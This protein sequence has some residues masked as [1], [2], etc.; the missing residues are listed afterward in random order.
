MADKYIMAID[1]GTTGTRVILFNHSGRIHSMAYREIE[2]IF[3]NPGW[4]E[5]NPEEYWETTM[6]CAEE[7]LAEGGASIDEVAG[8]GI[9]NQRETT[10]LWDKKTGKPVYNA[11]VWQCRRTADMCDKLKEAGHEEKIQEKTGLLIDAYFSG[12]KIKWI[13][14]NVPEA[15]EKLEQGR[16]CMGTIDS[17][18]I[19]KLTGGRRHVTDYSNASRTMLLNVHDLDWDQELFDI[20][21]LPMEIMPE[22]APSSGVMAETDPDVFFGGKIPVA[23]VAGDQHAATFG[24]ACFRP[25]MAKNTYGTALAMMMNIGTE[26]ILS[27]NG[28]TTDLG[29]VIGDQVDFALEGVIF[30]GGAAIQWLRDGL[31]I[32]DNPAEAD[33][34]AEGVENTGGVYLVPAFTGLC[35]PYWDMYARGT[36][37]GITRGTDKAHIARSALE[38]MAYQTKDV[39]EAM[40]S[41]SGEEIKTLRVDGGVTKSDFLMQFQADLLGV[42]VEKPE[43]T[44][45]AALGAAYLA[46]LGVDFWE[47]QEELEAQWSVQKAYEPQMDK[48]R[49]EELYAGWKNAVERSKNWAKE[50]KS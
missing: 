21:G 29:W 22:L 26:P 38:S 30:N 17:W 37:V 23:G 46:G 4:V 13:M 47:S 50:V 42:R 20:L 7:A 33:K 14:E 9:T 36:I 32:I 45:M 16:L 6:E 18:L 12:T 24:Q 15:R 40:Q 19:W 27:E 49:R 1:Q 8:I 34:L 41:D 28:L 2:Q 48:A 5:H 11:I 25:G 44:E 10:I 31:G 3:P 39:L 35:A 43:V